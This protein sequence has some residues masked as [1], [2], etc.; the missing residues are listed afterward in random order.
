MQFPLI[1][2]WLGDSTLGEE[3][4]GF[5]WGQVGIYHYSYE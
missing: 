3:I 5:Q 2:G 4:Q 1:N